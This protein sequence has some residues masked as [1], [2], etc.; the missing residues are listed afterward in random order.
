M[1]V[2]AFIEPIE[3]RNFIRCFT[4]NMEIPIW[5]YGTLASSYFLWENNYVEFGETITFPSKSGILK[6]F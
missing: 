5:D 1:S 6:T 2:T 4:S 3:V